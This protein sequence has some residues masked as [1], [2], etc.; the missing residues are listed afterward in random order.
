MRLLLLISL[1][2]LLTTNARAQVYKYIDSSKVTGY[3][4]YKQQVAAHPQK[5]LVNLKEFIPGVVLDIRYATANNFTGRPVYN[6]AAA[7]AR[8]PVAE[9][10]KA[11]Q[12]ELNKKGLGLKI[13][14]AYRPYAITVKFYEIATDTTYVADPRKGS[15]HNR[16]CA[17]DLTL[18]N[19]KTELEL[20]MPTGYDSFTPHASA[21]YNNLPLKKLN[22]RKLLRDVM[23]RHGFKVYSSEW[24]H[25]DYTGWQNFELLN[26]PFN[27]L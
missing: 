20:E 22:N 19:L 12:A 21:N 16:G 6:K 9:A 2:C 8:L 7:F 5:R 15:R 4:A 25:F 13:F 14:D 17:V 26:I 24:W 23:E 3:N 18:I 11:V 27:Q 10:L 1:A